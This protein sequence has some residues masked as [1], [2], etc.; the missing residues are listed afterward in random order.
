MRLVIPFALIL[1]SVGFAD[2]F[3]WLPFANLGSMFETLKQTAFHEKLDFNEPDSQYSFLEFGKDLFNNIGQYLSSAIGNE[4]KLTIATN[5]RELFNLTTSTPLPKTP[6]R[7]RPKI[8][9]VDK[10]ETTSKP[11]P[12]PMPTVFTF[13]YTTPHFTTSTPVP[14]VTSTYDPRPRFRY[15]TTTEPQIIKFVKTTKPTTTTEDTTTEDDIIRFTTTTERVRYATFSPNIPMTTSTTPTTTTSTFPTSTTEKS[16]TAQPSTTTKP[17]TTSPPT[18]QVKTI[19]PATEAQKIFTKPQY[20]IWPTTTRPMTSTSQAVIS[21]TEQFIRPSS[22]IRNNVWKKVTPSV[23]PEYT[24]SVFWTTPMSVTAELPSE[25][26]TI[27][28]LIPTPPSEYQTVYSSTAGIPFIIKAKKFT[29]PPIV[30]KIAVTSAPHTNKYDTCVPDQ[31]CSIK[32]KSFETSDPLFQYCYSHST[33]IDNS[34]QDLLRDTQTASSLPQHISWHS[35]VTPEIV[36]LVQTLM[37]LYR[38]SRCLVI[39]VFTGLGLLGVAERVDSRGIVVAL[40]H[41]AYAVFW[42]KIGQKHARKLT[43]TQMSRIQMRTS[44]SIEKS[45]P[46]LATNEPNTFD[47]VFL[48]DFKRENYLDDYEHAIR[49]IRSGGLLIINQALNGGGVM[50]S[51]DH[52]T[53]DDRVIRNMNIRIKQDP[54]VSASLLPYGGGTWIVTKN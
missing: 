11:T 7:F 43:A 13:P 50:S 10:P 14:E 35:S 33:M 37:S 32:L 12:R 8:I 52:M 45:L 27:T 44:E 47:F 31:R 20:Q 24:T 53:N 48:D 49:L 25:P 16:T 46:R 5:L 2:G 40:E 19:L 22:I 29:R 9:P 51:I 42:D 3:I 15:T 4:D 6:K 34:I 21:S 36:Q 39:G 23:T 30:E 41:P 28:M 18:T 26:S 1:T 38:P 17:T 54:R